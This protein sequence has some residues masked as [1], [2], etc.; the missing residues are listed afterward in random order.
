MLGAVPWTQLPLPSPTHP[1]TPP[2]P[3]PRAD[4]YFLKQTRISGDEVFVL[5]AHPGQWRTFVAPRGGGAA[6]LLASAPARPSYREIED[7]LRREYPEASANKGWLE[8]LQDEAKWVQDSL[9]Q[10]PGGGEQ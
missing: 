10:P 6:R 2:R 5:Y 7:T 8:R 3:P 9:K 1:P 4:S